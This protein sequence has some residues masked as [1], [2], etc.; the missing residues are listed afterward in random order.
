MKLSDTA[1]KNLNNDSKK[2]MMIADTACR[3][4]NLRIT[5][6]NGKTFY[7]RYAHPETK[8][9]VKWRL[10]RYP[11]VSLKSAREKVKKAREL[12]EQGKNP[13]DYFKRNTSQAKTKTGTLAD[14]CAAYVQKLTDDGKKTAYDVERALQ[15]DVVNT[16]YAKIQAKDITP[17]DI[18]KILNRIINRGAPVQAN[19]VR[20]YLHAAFKNGLKHD[21][22]PKYAGTNIKF[23]LTFNPV[24]VIEKDR[25]VE[26]VVDRVLSFEE[27]KTIVHDSSLSDITKL[28]IKLILLLG[29]RRPAEVIHIHMDELDF[30]EKT[31]KLPAERS[32]NGKPL[33]LPLTDKTIEVIKTA[34]D[35][36]G[37]GD[38][39]FP[40]RGKGKINKP[41]GRNTLNMAI[42][43]YCADTG[44]K[45]F[46]PR[47]LRTTF[48]TLA[49]S[50]GIS[51]EIR[52]RIQH[53][54]LN[55]VASKHY[56]FYDYLEE[57]K[58]ALEKWER[59]LIEKCD[60]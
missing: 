14:L 52:D 21:F 35:L 31:W 12:L 30:E 59:A 51:K 32:K 25:S 28:Q 23:E 15:K 60:F 4:L 58:E 34:H 41:C 17:D 40:Y 45:K 49:G 50:L 16:E 57:K 26:K 3:G 13:K 29:G 37:Q 38:Y 55:D 24:S 54:A 18:S 1:I 7:M 5:P 43:K 19:R 9:T 27:I 2:D 10:G 36:T 11:A 44:F 46:T 53:H 39:L 22:N 6:S 47:D 8:K 48:K 20:S 42:K 56:D 33:L